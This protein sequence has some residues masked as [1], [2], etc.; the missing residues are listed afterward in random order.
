MDT[1]EYFE[2]WAH[3]IG[4]TMMTDGNIELYYSTELPVEHL[5]HLIA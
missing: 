4:R 5:N 2:L 3:G 1:I